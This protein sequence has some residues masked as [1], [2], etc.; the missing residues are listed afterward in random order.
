MLA[1]DARDNNYGC[2]P[3]GLPITLQKRKQMSYVSQFFVLKRLAMWHCG[4]ALFVTTAEATTMLMLTES[5][6]YPF[7]E[8]ASSAL[9]AN[10]AAMCNFFV[11]AF[12]APHRFM[13]SG[14]AVGLS[15]VSFLAMSRKISCSK[16]THLC[17]RLPFF[18]LQKLI[19]NSKS[20]FD[21]CTSAQRCWSQSCML[22]A[23]FAWWKNI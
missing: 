7:S 13:P 9:F 18:L 2:E 16:S 6:I 10:R 21:H 3:K 23:R 5:R 14:V 1:Q 15:Q 8:Q 17:S 11:L 22:A 12:H 20:H 19:Q 4:G